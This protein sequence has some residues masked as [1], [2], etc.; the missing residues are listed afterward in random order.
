LAFN[1]LSVKE[2]LK[3]ENLKFKNAQNRYDGDV[4]LPVPSVTVMSLV[5]V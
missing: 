2:G 3:K 5:A 1:P 4:T